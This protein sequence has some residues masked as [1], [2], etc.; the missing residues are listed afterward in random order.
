MNFTM[1]INP[2]TKSEEKI[3]WTGSSDTPQMLG[4]RM[5]EWVTQRT[6]AILSRF[7][8]GPVIPHFQAGHPIAPET[9]SG[10]ARLLGHLHAL[11]VERLQGIRIEDWIR[12][13]LP[14]IDGPSTQTFGSMTLAETLLEWGPFENNP[15]LEG[16]SD[17]QLQNLAVGC[18]TTHIYKADGTIG[19]WSANY[20]MVLARTEFARQRLGLLTDTTILEAALEQCRKLLLNQTTDYFDDSATGVGRYDTYS[21][22]VMSLCGPFWHLLPQEPLRERLH[23]DVQMLETLAMENGACVVYGRSIGLFSIIQTM[24]QTTM[25]LREQLSE[26]PGRLLALVANAAAQLPVWF[27]DDL[28][29]AHR[30]RMTDGYRGPK[31]LLEMTLGIL[32]GGAGVARS[33]RDLPPIPAS[34]DPVFPPRDELIRFDRRNAGLWM[35]RNEQLS[36]QLPFVSAWLGSDYTPWMHSPGLFENPWDCPM[37]FG[38]PVVLHKGKVFGP[39]ELPAS[40]KKF[41]GGLTL[42][43]ESLMEEV[44]HGW[45][46]NPEWQRLDAKLSLTWSIEGECVHLE[47][48]LKLTQLPK[49]LAI[50][51]PQAQRSLMV[52][53]VECSEPV[54]QDVMVVDGMG[55]YHSCWSQLTAVHQLHLQPTTEVFIHFVVQPA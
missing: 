16:L 37:R 55:A 31:R 32:S 18:D 49:G 41:P 36:F 26:D 27:S 47:Q 8:S 20:W 12:R 11:G 24:G 21:M 3:G 25:A 33:L 15:L 9:Y 7:F 48:R 17:E 38:V 23:R 14:T 42:T 39:G 54:S 35:F 28:V 10:L 6:E 43:Y 52:K 13:I 34:K 40:V 50:S 30:Y 46:P 4:D 2:H 5:A 22:G 44:A 29:T 53:V 45:M 1:T 19:E 51:I